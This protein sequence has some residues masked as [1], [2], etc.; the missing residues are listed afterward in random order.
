MARGTVLQ[1]VEVAPKNFKK[2][3]GYHWKCTLYTG[4]RCYYHLLF[5]YYYPTNLHLNR[6]TYRAYKFRVSHLTDKNLL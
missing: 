5:G 1:M 3:L 2:N 6:L 4:K